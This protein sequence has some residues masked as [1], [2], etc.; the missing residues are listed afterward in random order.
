MHGLRVAVLVGQ[1]RACLADSLLQF[2]CQ[3]KIPGNLKD[4]FFSSGYL[5]NWKG[6]DMQNCI[7][8]ESIRRF[9]LAIA[10]ALVASLCVLM[11]APQAFAATKTMK[12]GDDFYA[13]NYFSATSSDK[14]V[15]RVI[16]LDDSVRII[17]VGFGKA[18][19]TMSNWY[20]DK[21]GEEV[22][23]DKVYKITVKGGNY[24]KRMCDG[25]YT[26]CKYSM[27]NLLRSM[28]IEPE[29]DEEMYGYTD[30]RFT[31]YMSKHGGKFLKG[32]GYTV[33]DKGKKIK[34]TKTG[35]VTVKYRYK[36][37]TY[38]MH[39]KSVHSKAQVV[40]ELTRCVKNDALQPWSFSLTSAKLEDTSY[41][42]N[43][44]MKFTVLNAYGQR[45]S[46]T[47]FGWY[48]YGYFEYYW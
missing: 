27:R 34:F 47:A 6:D 33:S 9:A 37:K 24:S 16:E 18:T 2:S 5:L 44:R 19:V 45:V 40:N 29:D 22:Y 10:F 11:A 46:S 7:R 23:V 30:G 8:S 4:T 39:F 20:E 41:A 38:K 48:Q 36:G 32:K 35:K 28:V 43:V 17:A 26:G 42:A 15:V 12:I 31:A 13:S 21:D 25:L 3:L 14:N 1:V